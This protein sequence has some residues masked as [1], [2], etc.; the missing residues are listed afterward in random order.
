MEEFH[1]TLGC[2]LEKK[3]V[4]GETDRRTKGP[5]AGEQERFLLSLSVRWEVTGRLQPRRAI[6]RHFQRCICMVV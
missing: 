1:S 2:L 5:L 6:L 4:T 3:A